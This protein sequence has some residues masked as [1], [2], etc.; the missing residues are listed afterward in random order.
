MG[1]RRAVQH[2]RFACI[3][4]CAFAAI[5]FF[6]FPLPGCSQDATDSA[7]LRGTVRDAQGRPLAAATVYLQPTGETRFLTAHP[8]SQGVYSF[9]ALHP[10]VYALRATMNG[11]GDASIP[12]LFLGPKE[13][14]NVDLTLAPGNS[15]QPKPTSEKPEFFDPPQFTVSGVTDATNLGGHGSDTIARTRE[16]IAKETASLGKISAGSIP[17]ASEAAERLLRAQADRE[18]GSFDANHRL[19]AALIENGKASEAIPYLERAAKLNPTGFENAYDLARANADAG[20]EERARESAQALLAH[21]DT[22]EVH[23]LL[24]NVQERLGDSLDA[25][26]EYQRAAELDPRETYLFDWGSELLLHHAPG[27]ALEVFNQGHRSFPRSV[28]MLVALGAAEFAR[29]SYDEAVRRVCQASDLD[30]GNS[31]PYVFLGRMQTSQTTSSGEL[32]EKLHRFVV[33]QPENA[34]A[35][36]YYAVSLWKSRK[37]PL[38]DAGAAQIE[39][40]LNAAI[41]LDPKFGA[42]YLQLGVLHSEQR[43]IQKAISDYQQSL[44]AAPEMPTQVEE[45]HYRL[46]QAYRQTGDT[47]KAKAEFRLY[48]Q[49]SK[50]S[51]ENADR[52]RRVIRQFVYTLRDQPVA[53]KP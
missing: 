51:A 30:P 4:S 12:S 38:D 2:R 11:Y 25:V 6:A 5:A 27:P 48:Q 9:T 33:L 24:A 35:N 50:E 1:L 43:N 41:R 26:H 45:A 34:Q 8:D 49:M 28:R 18:P 32:V 14:K 46:S 53:Q 42:A 19:G 7:M 20:N 52:E 23:H 17:P 16:T 36:Y 3:V 47:E 10:G 37:S 22:A 13:A 21:H 29:G 39:S 15:S 40:L 31:I 44:H